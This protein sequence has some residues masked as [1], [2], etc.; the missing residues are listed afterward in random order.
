MKLT[1]DCEVTSFVQGAGQGLGLA[2]T[3]VLLSHGIADRVYASFRSPTP[4]LELVNLVS[5]Y[6]EHLHLISLDVT[7]EDT[8]SSAV[9]QLQR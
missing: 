5:Q 9:Q 1:T 4:S 7:R 3:K 8:I 6:P 2:F